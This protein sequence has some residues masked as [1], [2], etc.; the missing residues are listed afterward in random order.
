VGNKIVRHYCLS[1]TSVDIYSLNA[2]FK[3]TGVLQEL[4]NRHLLVIDHAMRCPDLGALILIEEILAQYQLY[5]L[6][7]LNPHLL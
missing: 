5:L 4:I 2:L 7:L 3:L 1:S 6:V